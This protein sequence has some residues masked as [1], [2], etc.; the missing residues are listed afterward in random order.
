MDSD[1]KEQAEAL[2]GELGTNFTTA[3]YNFVR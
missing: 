3:F 2:F 1:L